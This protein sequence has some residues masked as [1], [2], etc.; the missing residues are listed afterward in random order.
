MLQKA[1]KGN[2][3]CVSLTFKSNY[4]KNIRDIETLFRIRNLKKIMHY[5]FMY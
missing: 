2:G 1:A 3:I 4:L 5:D